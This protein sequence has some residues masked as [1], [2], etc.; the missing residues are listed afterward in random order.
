MS[1]K[2]LDI[3]IPAYNANKTIIRT[4]SSVATQK[5]NFKFKVTIVNDASKVGYEKEI[6]LFK[7]RLDINV[8]NLEKNVG[9]GVARQTG[10][11]KTHG[12]YIVFIDSDDVFYDCISLQKLYDLMDDGKHDYGFGKLVVEENGTI[13]SYKYHEECLHSKIFSRSLIE[14]NN[15][16]F[17]PSRTS[18]D[19]SFNHICLSYAESIA[20]VDDDCYIYLN[21]SKSLTK[22]ISEKKLIENLIDYADNLIYT[23]KNISNRYNDININF[24]INGFMYIWNEYQKISKIDNNLVSKL[25]KKI[26][27][28]VD[29]TRDYDDYI[30]NDYSY[31]I[32][33]KNN[34]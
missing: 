9:V 17:N 1:K 19:N 21:N 11:D 14:K 4:L 16:K 18:E 27:E 24:H 6:K 10:I 25:Y 22:G 13:N 5:V 34:I 20:R 2:K 32:D 28:Y 3:I 31:I 29:F 30:V 26:K 8:I 15:I 33:I 23:F 7:D 12:D